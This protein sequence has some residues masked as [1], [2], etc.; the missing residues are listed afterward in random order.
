MDKSSK[1]FL[2]DLLTTPSPS[3]FEQK[4]QRVVKGYV[5][6]FAET[7]EV[8]LHGNL[9]AGINTKAKRRVMLAGHCDQIGF[10][11]KSINKEGYISLA[12]VGGIDTGVMPAAHITIWTDKGPLKGVVGRKAIH[13]QSAEERGGGKV[14]IDKVW[15]DIGAKNQ[16]EAERQIQIGDPAT[17]ELGVTELGN[18]LVVSPAL[19]D[20]SG[21]FV[22][23]ECLRLCAKSKLN[24]ALYAVSSVQEEVGLRGAKT[25]A[26]SIDPEIGIAID[27]THAS[28]YP[29]LDPAKV[30]PCKLGAGPVIMR[31]PNINP[32][33]ESQLV[34]MAK[35]NKIKY[36]LCP[37]PGI[38][39][40]DANPIQVS[41]GG[42]AAASI[43]IPNRYMHTQVETCC[44]KD[45]EDSAKLLAAFVKSIGPKSDFRPQ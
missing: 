9:I 22:A 23:M 8:D 26:Y 1:Q 11:V 45:L 40:N 14:D 28:D 44:L 33:V 30:T 24:V 5:K 25:A 17:F 37:Y 18:D 19:D 4:I 13:L 16:K 10:M 39:G 34:M 38:L 21:L 29:G 12:P 36:Q 15:V 2:F 27:V 42:V 6:S 20:K 35:K 31:G 32:V 41:R 3:G 7:V 43:G